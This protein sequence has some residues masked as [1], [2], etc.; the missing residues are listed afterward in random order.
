MV[1]APLDNPNPGYKIIQDS[2]E[3]DTSV[4][5]YDKNGSA[6][7]GKLGA[8]NLLQRNMKDI[9]AQYVTDT[10]A[11]RVSLQ[12]M[13]KNQSIFLTKR[14]VIQTNLSRTLYI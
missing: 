8:E 7:F 2:G 13:S 5:G 9:E 11:L 6:V 10:D 4:T 1:K 12:V 3:L 14:H